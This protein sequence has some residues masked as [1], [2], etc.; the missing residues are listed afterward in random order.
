MVYAPYSFFA[1]FTSL[2]LLTGC[3]RDQK[4]EKLLPPEPVVI[5]A[6][7]TPQPSTST[8]PT[9]TNEPTSSE[10]T[11]PTE[12][13]KP[14]PTWAKTKG[15]GV[16]KVGKPYK[17]N[18]VWYFPAENPRYDEIGFAG[19]YPKNFHGQRTANGEIYG[20]DL[21]TASHKTLPLPSVVQ[22]TNLNN[23]KSL[24]LRI[25]DRGPFVNDR[26]IDLSEKAAE[27][28]EVSQ[29]GPTKVRIEILNQESQEAAG[30]V[31]GSE[32]AVL[33]S[34]AYPPSIK[35]SGTSR[36]SKPEA[37]INVAA[38]TVASTTS[39]NLFDK[40]DTSNT[41]SN[42]VETHES[43]QNEAAST[44]PPVEQVSAPGKAYY[45]QAG[46]FSNGENA[47]KLASSLSTIGQTENS[48]ISVKGK[49][50]HRVRVGPFFSMDEAS[51]ALKRIQ[52]NNLP[53]AGIVGK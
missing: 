21:L 12:P 7:V 3:L 52:Q 39:D 29:D 13:P 9:S 36:P 24:I 44:L 49:D 37:F 51:D 23:N 53:D 27:L 31:Q 41:E 20:R 8:Q 40:S 18:G 17:V 15:E 50:L 45:V 14:L 42:A 2:L 33:P 34:P 48:L 32:K 46:V 1:V 11:Q 30:A 4:P 43:V 28:L 25:N 10:I 16:Y 47:E 38:T 22:V 35:E 26:L 19:T 6:D 5:K